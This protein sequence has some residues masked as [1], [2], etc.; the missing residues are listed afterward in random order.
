MRILPC[1]PSSPR[2]DSR[3]RNKVV[4]QIDALDIVEKGF[5]IDRTGTTVCPM[6][7][8]LCFN[9]HGNFCGFRHDPIAPVNRCRYIKNNDV[10]ARFHRPPILIR[11]GREGVIKQYSNSVCVIRHQRGARV[12]TLKIVV[13][14]NN[15]RITSRASPTPRLQL[16]S[17]WP[18]FVSRPIDIIADQLP[19]IATFSRLVSRFDESRGR[20]EGGGGRGKTGVNHLSILSS[21]MYDYMVEIVCNKYLYVDRIIVVF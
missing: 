10:V 3:S 13:S 5:V 16:S 20:G 6:A 7:R 12:T 14:E 8:P 1:T 9:F 15:F 18:A 17:S 19:P 21:I 11:G 4:T 2:D